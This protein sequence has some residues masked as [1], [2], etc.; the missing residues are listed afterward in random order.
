MTRAPSQ[1]DLVATLVAL[2][3]TEE[4]E[5]QEFE[6]FLVAHSDALGAALRSRAPD[7]LALLGLSPESRANRVRDFIRQAKDREQAAHASAAQNL[8]LAAATMLALSASWENEQVSLDHR[9]VLGKNLLADRAK[10]FVR[11][12]VEGRVPLAIRREKL[13]EAGNV[14]KFADLS[15][16]IDRLG[17]MFQWRQGRGGLLLVNQKVDARYRELVLPVVIARKRAST[18]ERSPALARQSCSGWLGDVFTDLTAF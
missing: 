8:S 6:E 3:E 7:L 10:K 2:C 12:D 5:H 11:F 15:C 4:T 13:S 9:I 14:L 1:R 17:L 18:Y 16:S